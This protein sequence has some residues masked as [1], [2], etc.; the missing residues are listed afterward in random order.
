MSASIAAEVWEPLR[1]RRQYEAELRV[2][3][4]RIVAVA[5][6]YLIHLLHYRATLGDSSVWKFFGLDAGVGL[7]A[8][9]HTA[10]TSLVLAW[11]MSAVIVQQ[12]VQ[13]RLLP[14]WLM[15]ASTA[16][17]L[18]FLTGALTLSSGAA[19]PLVVGYFLVVLMSGLRFD[20]RL[21]RATTVGAIAGYLFLLGCARW[22]VGLLQ[23]H[24]LPLVPRYQQL[25]L[26]AALVLAGT[27]VGQWLRHARKLAEDLVEQTTAER[28]A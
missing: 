16:A 3:V 7:S 25:M 21:V 14:P 1:R 22:P 2:N 13:S 18:C 17:D 27:L 8:A 28:S 24:P 26:T 20:L 11:L 4:V 19:S 10:V 6:F 12:F 9:Q 5:T 15:Y 23:E